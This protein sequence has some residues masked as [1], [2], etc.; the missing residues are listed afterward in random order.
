MEEIEDS[1]VTV[2][3][4]EFPDKPTDFIDN[5]DGTW[6]VK[7]FDIQRNFDYLLIQDVKLTNY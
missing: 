2:M 7:I 5:G 6:Y 1:G 3:A 4:D